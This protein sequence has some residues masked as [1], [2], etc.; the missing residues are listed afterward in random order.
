MIDF[1]IR[2][3]IGANHSVSMLREVKKPAGDLQA[4]MYR[5][6]AVRRVV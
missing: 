3:P 2:V 1:L 4:F 5:F 6:A